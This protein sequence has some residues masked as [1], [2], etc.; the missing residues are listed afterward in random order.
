MHA[1]VGIQHGK[2]SNPSS[3]KVNLVNNSQQW[4]SNEKL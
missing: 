1:A 2:T 3:N 4:S